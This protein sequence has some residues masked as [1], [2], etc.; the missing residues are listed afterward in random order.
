MRFL[1][2]VFV[3]FFLVMAAIAAIRRLLAPMFDQGRTAASSSRSQKSSGKLVADPVC[4]T[5]IAAATAPSLTRGDEVFYF[6]SEDCRLKFEER[7]S[8]K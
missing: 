2:R 7:S 6:C 5:Y 4:G 1:I 3:I 8:R